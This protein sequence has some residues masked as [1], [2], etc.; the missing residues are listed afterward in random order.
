MSGQ[1]PPQIGNM[2]DLRELWLSENRLTGEIPPQIGNLDSLRYLGLY[3]NQLTGQI[4]PQIGNLSN[5]EYL[6]V[7]EN[8]LTG[9]IPLEIG[10]L[11]KL[12]ELSLRNNENM[13]GPIPI[14]LTAIST[15]ELLFLE[16]TQLCVPNTTAFQTWLDGIND[17]KP[18]NVF[19]DD[20][21]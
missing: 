6:Q 21:Q 1:I 11:T 3:E 13:S 4:P 14:E 7:E 9:G 8:Q 12:L 20:G 16:G 10:N 18:E 2:G 5:L 17:V 19:C 15:L